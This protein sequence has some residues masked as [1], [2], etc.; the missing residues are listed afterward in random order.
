MK[1]EFKTKFPEK[2]KYYDIDLDNPIEELRADL[3]AVPFAIKQGYEVIEGKTFADT[4]T[5]KKGN[6]SVWATRSVIR[7]ELINGAYANHKQY[8]TYKE[9]LRS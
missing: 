8:A 3:K 7:A 2:Y 5:F 6:V 9:A 1:T 4:V